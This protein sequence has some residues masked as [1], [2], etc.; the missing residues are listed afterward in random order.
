MKE[1]EQIPQA[2][3]EYLKSRGFEGAT[4]EEAFDWFYIEHGLFCNSRFEDPNLECLK[5]LI[6]TLKIRILK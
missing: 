2:D 4:I 6:Q 5:Q 1:I 3:L